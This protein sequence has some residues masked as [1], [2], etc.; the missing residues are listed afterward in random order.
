MNLV[1]RPLLPSL[2]AIA[3][4]TCSAQSARLAWKPLGEPGC[5]GWVTSL[6]VSPH[7]PRRV[8]VGGD[9]LGIGLSTDGGDTW[10]PTFGLKSWEIAD[11]T[12][13]P[14]NSHIVW[15]G[16]MSGPYRS[17]DGGVTWTEMRQGF[18]P[19]A[20]YAYSAPVQA[21]L[22]DPNQPDRLLALGGSHRR[23]A[24]PGAP[25]W[26]AVWESRD[27]GQ[28]W[29]R[30]STVTDEKGIGRNI[31]SGG[32]GAGSSDRVYVAADR[33]GVFVSDDGGR[34]WQARNEG[35]PHLNVNQLALH[36][37][38]RDTLWAALGDTRMGDAGDYTPGGIYRSDDGGKSWRPA[39]TGLSRH[40]SDNENLTARYDAVAISPVSPERMVTCDT[41]WNGGTLYTSRNG[42]AEWRKC[43]TRADVDALLTSGLGMT[44]LTCA[45]KDPDTLYAAGAEYILRSGDFGRTWKD[46]SARREGDGWR[47]T[48]FTGWVCTQFRF[49]PSNPRHAVWLAMDAGNFWQSNDGLRSWTRARSGLEDWGGASDVAFAGERAML[50]TLGQFGAFGGIGR[51]VDG[52]RKWDILAGAARG[53]PE[54]GAP[55][56]PTV[57]IAADPANAGV[58]WAAVGGKVYQTTDG[59]EKWAVVCEGPGM[60]WLASQPGKTLP[61]YAGGKEGVYRSEDGVTFTPMAGSPRPATRLAVDRD[62]HVWATSWRGVGGLWKYDGSAWTRVRDGLYISCVA[63]DP[64]DAQ[65]V[66]VAEDDHPFHD[67]SNATGVWISEDGGKTW[68]RQV[69]GLPVLRGSVLAINPHDPEQIV[70]GA[71]GRGFFTAR[72]AKK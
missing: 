48:G 20:D 17:L 32:F 70:F 7:D 12:F 30:L 4:A 47:G 33:L 16:T 18:P 27:A 55:N 67:V 15:A 39:Q 10:Q 2:L 46:I 5:G 50:V 24:S 1:L 42:A 41:S 54:R 28:H 8:L 40:A 57:G 58:V 38:K 69:D 72:W 43:V 25:L 44:V 11:I 36:P 63:V 14:V 6:A 51:S 26:G 19:V 29:T 3:S 45:P 35:L 22:F 21:V 31:V 64:T 37:T 9:M 71:S 53:L 62:G 13:H 56:T 66:A 60:E 68:S 65:R 59:G 23:W 34:T 52:G 49:D 61:L